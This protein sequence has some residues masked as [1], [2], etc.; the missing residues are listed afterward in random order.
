MP[1]WFIIPVLCGVLTSAVDGQVSRTPDDFLI[2]HHRVGKVTI[3][4]PAQAV[5]ERFRSADI[6]LVD[7][8][9]EG[10]LSPALVIAPDR[11]GRRD[12][13][14]VDL[15]C[16]EKLVVWRILVNDPAFKTAQG[17]GPGSR[18]GDLRKAYGS[19]RLISGEGNVGIWVESLSATFLVNAL[20]VGSARLGRDGAGSIADTVRVK[21]V[22]VVK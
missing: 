10:M 20:D 21:A 17:I 1:K 4:A 19:G 8:R 12:A 11:T 13:L 18:V 14:I 5:Y 3:D 16:N 6:R 9:L 2:E 22:L 15:V 7:R